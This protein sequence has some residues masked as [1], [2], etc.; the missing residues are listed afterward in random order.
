M[1]LKGEETKIAK[2]KARSVIK[3]SAMELLVYFS[4]RNLDAIQRC[5]RNTLESIRKRITASMMAQ[6]GGFITLLELFNLNIFE[7]TRKTLL[8]LLR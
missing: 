5:I 8:T 7:F 6:Y 1:K 3:E 2:T 4:Q